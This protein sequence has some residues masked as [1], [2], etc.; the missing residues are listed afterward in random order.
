MKRQKH[1]NGPAGMAL[2][3]VVDFCRRAQ[4][5]LPWE[6]KTETAADRERNDQKRKD[7]ERKEREERNRLAIQAVNEG[8]WYWDLQTDKI[9]FSAAWAAML[10]F[11]DEEI[12]ND[13]EEWFG[14]VHTYHLPEL[15]R[16]LSAHLYGKTDQFQS[17]YRIQHRDG[18]FMWVMSRGVAF[19]DDEGN[20]VA[21]AGGQL[22]M[23][24]M[25]TVENKIVDETF[26]DKL[27]N[28]PNREACMIRLERCLQRLRGDQ[29]YLFAVMFLD[30]DRFKVVN[31]SFG[32]LVG[33]ELL[34]AAASR[35]KSNLRD[36]TSD[37]VARFGG[38]EFVVLLEE[39]PQLDE[40][41][42]VAYRIRDSL[43][44]AF[45]TREA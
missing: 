11:E 18:S 4:S 39:L 37:M 1:Q 10:G 14:R 35:I 43:G 38:D 21:I 23:T 32:H 45:Q 22:D 30:L 33:D 16:T 25:L 28:L 2:L 44:S 40:A 13:P 8:H 5:L 42:T 34:A 15:K 7:Q 29:S 41:L 19:R 20:P 9:T 3:S 6:R 27:T 36:S 17:Q 24:C 12:S 26:R 31:D